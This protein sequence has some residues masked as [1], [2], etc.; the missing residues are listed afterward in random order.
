VQADHAADQLLLDAYS[1]AVVHAVDEVAPAVVKVAA[2]GRGSGSGFLFTPDGLV[3]TN[4]HV[5]AAAQ[6]ATVTLLDGRTTRAEPVG[7]DPDTDLAVLRVAF[8]DATLPWARF[9]DSSALRTGQV[10]VAI[11]NPFGFQHSVTAGVV[12]AV[13]RSLRSR[14]GRLME[15]L[16]QTD[17]ALNPG[18]SGGPLVTTDGAVIGV[19][20]AMIVPAQGLSFAVGGNTA[21]FVLSALVTEGRVRR[22]VIGVTGQTVPVPRRLAR[23]HQLAVSSGVLAADVER[24]SAA[25][26]AG[27][28]PGDII[29]SL[30]GRRVGGVDDLHR[31]M[32]ASRIGVP[33]AATILRGIERRTLT[34][35]PRERR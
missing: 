7:D 2:D 21:Q 8:A 24:G 34:L 10:V 25:D 35:I 31:L 28:R 32:T 23:A 20:T 27:L 5:I 12:S 13:G 1:R 6:G 14:S 11:G 33:C 22:S 16:V 29:V 26:V 4:S 18:N 15:D 9:G 19:N 3:L 17:A 30:A